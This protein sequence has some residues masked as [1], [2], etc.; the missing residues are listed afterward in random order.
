MERIEHGRAWE[1]RG[2]LRGEDISWEGKGK[3]EGSGGGGGEEQGGERRESKNGPFM[4]T[5]LAMFG[6]N[7]T[8]PSVDTYKI[9]P[10]I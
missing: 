10:W 6:M 9:R 8:N 4:H 2:D 5:Y 1:R 7:L 3:E